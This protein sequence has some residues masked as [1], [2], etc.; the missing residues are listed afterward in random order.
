MYDLKRSPPGYDFL[1]F[2]QLALEE[3]AQ[4]I[5][6]L[7]GFGRD[8]GTEADE[9]RKLEKIA[10]RLCES[11]GL[12]YEL[13]GEPLHV[14]TVKTPLRPHSLKWMRQLEKPF[15]LRPSEQTLDRVNDVL[16][17]RRSIVVILRESSIQP[18]RNSGQDWRAWAWK[19]EAVVLEDGEKTDM[20]P[21]EYAAYMDL[22]S[23]SM[24]VF[25]G[26]MAVALYS[27]HRPYLV[28]R[29]LTEHYSALSAGKWQQWGWKIGDQ[30]PWAGRH[31]KLVWNYRD[32]FDT[33]E[34]AYQE[35]LKEQSGQGLS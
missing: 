23:I 6:F 29:T 15:P 10:F 22:A 13:S 11:Y 12:K 7:P 34:G 1:Q 16:K 18:M 35:Y 30:Y 19:H 31:Q 17:G 9:R 26:P 2:L 25:S 20:P 5:R 21:E 28:L 32:D 24:G 27:E 33:I 14:E 4:A 8:H 3:G